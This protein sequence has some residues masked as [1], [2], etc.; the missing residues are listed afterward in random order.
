MRPLALQRYCERV[1]VDIDKI[2]Q[3][4]ERDAYERYTEIYKIVDDGDRKMAQMFDGFSRSKALFQLA[5]YYGNNLLNDDEIAQLSE[6]ARDRIF[7]IQ[8]I[9]AEE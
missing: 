3:N 1:M 4:S 9:W 8:K 2:I 6:V 7:S 5:L